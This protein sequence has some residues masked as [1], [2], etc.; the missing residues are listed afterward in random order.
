MSGWSAAAAY[1][2][3]AAGKAYE[4]AHASWSYPMSSRIAPVSIM[5]SISMLTARR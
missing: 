1:A 4:I 3:N 2:M 5:N